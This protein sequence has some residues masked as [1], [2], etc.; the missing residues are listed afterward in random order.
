MRNDI[1]AI[2]CPDIHGR[3]FWE[4]AAQEYDGTIPFI[5]LG[6]YLDPYSDENITVEDAQINFNKIWDFKEKWGD[7]VILLV[8]NHD[9]SYKD[10]IFQCCRFSMYSSGWYK[11]FLNKHWEHFNLSYDIKTDDKTFI[12]SHAGIHPSWLKENN[13]EEIYDA[14]YI[15][16][17]FMTN[18]RAFTDYSVYRG[19]YLSAGSPVWADIREFS[20]VDLQD[21]KIMQVVGHTQLIKDKL[22][23]KNICCID[24]RQTFVITN[25]NKI[26]KYL[27]KKEE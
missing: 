3:N 5:F 20:K 27:D 1:K 13:F 8:G 17:L 11:D 4:K 16:S 19:G 9:L 12:F 2:V 26:E 15:N 6:D 14:D 18:K 21:D 10:Y 24:S 7:N 23:F 22:E 25:D